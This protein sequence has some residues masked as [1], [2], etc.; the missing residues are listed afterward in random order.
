MPARIEKEI[1]LSIID[2]E[3]VSN[4][5]NPAY[6]IKQGTNEGSGDGC[7]ISWNKEFEDMTNFDPVEIDNSPCYELF[8]STQCREQ[9]SDFVRVCRKNCEF[10][11]GT[12]LSVTYVLKNLWINSKLMKRHP[13]A[14]IKRRVDVYIFPFVAKNHTICALHILIDRGSVHSYEHFEQHISQLKTRKEVTKF[15]SDKFKHT[16][17]EVSSHIPAKQEYVDT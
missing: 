13:A 7:I 1:E 11:T 15:L 9:K 4:I 8:E 10:R 5:R 16:Q 12:K 3:D 14:Y 17:E 6:V 2:H